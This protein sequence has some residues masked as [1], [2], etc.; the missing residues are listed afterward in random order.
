[1]YMVTFLNLIYTRF[2]CIPSL[3]WVTACLVFN[4]QLIHILYCIPPHLKMPPLVRWSSFATLWQPLMRHLSTLWMGLRF[5]IQLP[6]PAM[7]SYVNTASLQLIL[8]TK[9]SICSCSVSF[10]TN[11]TKYYYYCV[12]NHCTGLCLHLSCLSCDNLRNKGTC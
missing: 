8:Q 1:M 6:V 3:Q 11:C 9:D 12:H 5:L 10:F 7:H 4:P 2:C